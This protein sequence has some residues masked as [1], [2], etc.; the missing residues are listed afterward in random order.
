ME[1]NK[2]PGKKKQKGEDFCKR[3]SSESRENKPESPEE[4][5]RTEKFLCLVLPKQDNLGDES[6]VLRRE[7]REEEEAE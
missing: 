5:A 6:G 7:R 1:L 3:V 4:E 2:D